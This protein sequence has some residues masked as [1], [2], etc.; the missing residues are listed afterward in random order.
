M[1]PIDQSNPEEIE[2]KYFEEELICKHDDVEQLESE[3]A[4]LKEM[5]HGRSMQ[6]QSTQKILNEK[7][8]ECEVLK[9]GRYLMIKRS[10][11][12]QILIENGVQDATR[13]FSALA[14]I[15]FAPEEP[16]KPTADDIIRAF[17]MAHDDGLTSIY[18]QTIDK[19]REYLG[20]VPVKKAPESPEI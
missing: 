15:K 13:I 5:E 11:F 9:V 8:N 1:F 19:A 16:E 7:T 10:E 20:M 3:N 4:A 2:E 14:G 12:E 17:V 18:E 6:L